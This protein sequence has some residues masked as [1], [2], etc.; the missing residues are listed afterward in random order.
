MALSPRTARNTGQ[1]SVGRVKKFASV[2]KSK[3]PRMFRL[4]RSAISPLL[5]DETLLALGPS[6]RFGDANEKTQSGPDFL[7][8]LEKAAQDPV[9]LTKQMLNSTKILK[10][11]GLA[12]KASSLLPTYSFG[13]YVPGNFEWERKWQNSP[14]DYR[15]LI[16]A[17]KDFSGSAYKLAEALNLHS[18]FAC[19]LITFESHQFGYAN[20]LIVLEKSQERSSLLLAEAEN[21]GTLI[22][23]DE[24]SWYHDSLAH[25][26][27]R[28]HKHDAVNKL[29]FGPRDQRVKCFTLYGG[30]TRKY[31]NVASWRIAL[32]SFDSLLAF[33]PD[34][35]IHGLPNQLIPHAI[36]VEKTSMAWTDSSLLHHS[37]STLK[38]LRK[39]SDLFFEALGTLEESGNRAW[40]KWEVDFVTGVSFEEALKRKRLASLSFDQAGR[41]GRISLGVDSVIGWYG[42]SAIESLAMGIPV[43]AHLSEKAL[44]NAASF[45]MRPGRGLIPV[46]LSSKDIAEKI[47]DFVRSS[48]SEKLELAH[49]ARL[50]A[51]RWHS[52]ESV[53]SRL[54]AHL[55]T[56]RDNH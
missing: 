4:M 10:A 45:G 8:E 25:R 14:F 11:T 6:E 52:Y 28:Q 22:L 43:I 54:G 55:Q 1:K 41:E 17:P 37:V 3:F 34:L 13:S 23:K 36:N 44:S 15:V 20:D 50:Y 39:G 53:A 27:G 24:Q 26:P 51:S 42:N 29:F 56:L 49:A 21:A 2:V 7:E 30:Y 48:H 38:P 47:L 35:F 19:R 16:I 18:D 46:K 12:E 40:K 9:A 32:E 31:R 5:S 33:T